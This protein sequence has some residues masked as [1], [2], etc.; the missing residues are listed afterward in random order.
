MQASDFPSENRRSQT[1]TILI[2]TVSGHAKIKIMKEKAKNHFEIIMTY[3]MRN[4]KV[5]LQKLSSELNRKVYAVWPKD[6]E[7]ERYFENVNL[8]FIVEEE[9]NN[10]GK[11][12]TWYK[13]KYDYKLEDINVR[14][15]EFEFA[16]WEQL[17]KYEGA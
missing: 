6:E 3:K 10:F 1:R 9:K 2:P 8:F 7:L 15:I 5:V 12:I 16:V 17:S 4:I 14:N 11:P 13:V